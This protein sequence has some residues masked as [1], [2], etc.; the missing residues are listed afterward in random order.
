KEAARTMI[1]RVERGEPVITTVEHVS[2]I[3]NIVESSLGFVAGLLSMENI[4]VIEVDKD[5]Y[6]AAVPIS[7][8]VSINDAI[9]TL[10]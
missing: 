5:D 6:E 10:I 8:G 3:A 4:E 7:T 2:E 1:L 9:V